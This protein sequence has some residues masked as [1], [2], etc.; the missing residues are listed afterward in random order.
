VELVCAARGID[1][2]APLH[3]AVGTGAALG[4]LRAAGVPGYGPDRELS[5]ELG[6][7]EELLESGA[8]LREVEA[9]IGELA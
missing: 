7:A 4:A 5:P 9:A 2:R 8:L 6:V 1:L 3:P